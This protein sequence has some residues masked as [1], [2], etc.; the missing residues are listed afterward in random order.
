MKV[1]TAVFLIAI[2]LVLGTTKIGLFHGMFEKNILTFNPGWNHKAETL[3]KFQDVRELQATIK[4]R[5]ITPVT[6]A[7]PAINGPA[8]FV[9]VDPDGNTIYV[10]QHVPKSK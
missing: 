8:S 7:D 1:L 2:V 10:D 5:G 4:K 6:E 9:I 3:K